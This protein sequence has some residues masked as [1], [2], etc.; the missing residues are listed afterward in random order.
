MSSGGNKNTQSYPLHPS[1]YGAEGL[2]GPNFEGSIFGTSSHHYDKLHGKN[3]KNSGSANSGTTNNGSTNSGSNNS[4]SNNSGDK[5]S[6][7]S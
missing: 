6:S 5:K 1:Q 2:P 3:S 7:S 4:G